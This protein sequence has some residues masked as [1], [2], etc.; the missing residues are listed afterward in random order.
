MSIKTESKEKSSTSPKA[1]SK[2]E[3]RVIGTSEESQIPKDARDSHL[4]LE[5]ANFSK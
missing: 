5:R 2:Q 1:C 4:T 3:I